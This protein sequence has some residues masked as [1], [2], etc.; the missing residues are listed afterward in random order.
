MKKV[1]NIFDFDGTLFN[2]PTP[3][4]DI[5]DA[6]TIGKLK[7]SYSQYGY[8]WFRNTLTLDDQYIDRSSFKAHVV[9]DAINSI[10]DESA[11]TAVLTG[12]TVDFESIIKSLCDERGLV[13]DY[14]GLKPNDT[15]ETTVEFKQAFIARLLAE[16]PGVDTIN[17]WDDRIKHVSRFK[18]YLDSLGVKNTVTYIDE[19]EP[20][21]ENHDVERELVDLLMKDSRIIHKIANKAPRYYGVILDSE[22]RELL[23][24]ICDEFIPIEWKRIMHHMT[25]SQG[26]SS[27]PVI[28]D[29]ITENLSELV[30]ITATEIGI[31]QDAIALKIESDVPSK[32]AIP[33]ITVAV[34]VKGKPVNSNFITNWKALDKPIKLNGRVGAQY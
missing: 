20:R 17:M 4:P 16:N 33:H 21:I 14:Y 32:N 12:R 11:I 19:P 5:W 3:N 2:S 26:E 23:N 7:N 31:S 18:V 1:I 15:N 22:S 29:Y 34:P 9:A 25:I 13:F 30:S 6:R 8:G 27:N 24:N 10:N 28:R